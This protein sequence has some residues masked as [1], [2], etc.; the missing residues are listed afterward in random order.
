MAG[1]IIPL[2]QMAEKARRFHF[3]YLEDREKSLNM[4]KD[5]SHST[6]SY[7]FLDSV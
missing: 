5:Q 1:T 6:N 3:D 2:K 4:R 7:F